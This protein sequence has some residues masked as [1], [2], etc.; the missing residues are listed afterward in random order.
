MCCRRE[1]LY[2]CLLLQYSELSLSANR[3][4]LEGI[5]PLN[6]IIVAYGGLLKTKLPRSLQHCSWIPQDGAKVPFFFVSYSSTYLKQSSLAPR[7]HTDSSKAIFYWYQNATRWRW[8]TAFAFC[9]LLKT[10]LGIFR[11][12]SQNPELWVFYRLIAVV[13]ED[14]LNADEC[15]DVSSSTLALIWTKTAAFHHPSHLLPR[16]RPLIRCKPCHLFQAWEFPSH[17]HLT[18]VSV[19]VPLCPLG[20]PAVFNS[21]HLCFDSRKKR[22]MQTSA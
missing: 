21:F 6:C 8:S 11:S 9:P 22:N 15:R 2:V 4:N 3:E 13:S 19:W 1:G 16:Q 20:L 17:C 12:F 5:E 14:F 10:K 18:N 7:C